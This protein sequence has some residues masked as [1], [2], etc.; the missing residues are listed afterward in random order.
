[1]PVQIDEDFRNPVNTYVDDGLS[2]VDGEYGLT[3]T[4]EAIEL[5]SGNTGRFRVFRGGCTI[6]RRVRNNT[7]EP[8]IFYTRLKNV[9]R[10]RRRGSRGCGA[11]RHLLVQL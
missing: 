8:T 7:T 1:M 6:L 3:A 11:E 4:E 9:Q 10:L 2:V 5:R